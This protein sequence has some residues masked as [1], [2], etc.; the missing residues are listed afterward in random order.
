MVSLVIGTALDV[1]LG[2][3]GVYD[4]T[5]QT[6][7]IHGPQGLLDVGTMEKLRCLV[8]LNRTQS[9]TGCM[10]T[11]TCG[12]TRTLKNEDTWGLDSQRLLHTIRVFALWGF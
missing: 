11:H 6:T 8:S 1:I 5:A 10:E 3:I 4:L 9:Q 12:H 7:Y 2:Y